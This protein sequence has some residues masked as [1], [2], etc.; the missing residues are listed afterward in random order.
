MHF[1]EQLFGFAP[2]GGSG[3]LELALL[4]LFVSLL[5]IVSR[6]GQSIDSRQLKKRLRLQPVNRKKIGVGVSSLVARGER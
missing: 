1:I 3:L 5:A 2:D 6:R 4:T